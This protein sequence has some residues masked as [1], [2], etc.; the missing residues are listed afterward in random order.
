MGL[1]QQTVLAALADAALLQ[2]E[3]ARG[4]GDGKAAQ[5]SLADR[6][7]EAEQVLKAVF[8]ECPSFEM[9][10]PAML[11][12]GVVRLP[13]TCHFVPGVPVKPMLAKPTHGVHE[14]LERFSDVEFTCE[15]KYDGERAQIHVLEDGS[16]RVFSRNC[17]DN[18]L[19]YPDITSTFARHLRPGVRSAVFDCEAVAFDREAGKIL[20][21]QILSTRSRKNVSAEDV[22]IQAREEGKR[23]LLSRLLR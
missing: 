2:E 9:I 3:A 17:E 6:L 7:A 11:R 23:C 1:A 8:C 18:T 13:E 15:Y 14:V 19:K 5:A 12:D 22:K 10:V 21:F 20:P 16:V 4:D